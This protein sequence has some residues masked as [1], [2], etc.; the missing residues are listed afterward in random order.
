M[1]ASNANTHHLPGEDTDWRKNIITQLRDRN[2]SETYCF[3]DLICLHNRLLESANTLKLENYQLSIANE[4]LKCEVGSGGFGGNSTLEARLLAHAEELATLHKRRGEHTQ[5]IVDLNNKLQELRKELQTKESSIAESLEVNAGLRAE[6]TRCVSRERELENVNQMLKDEHQALQLAFAALEEKLRKVQE[7]NRQLVERLIRYK[8]KDAEKMNEENDNF[9]NEAFTSPT[10]FL[11][12]TLSKFGKR[13]AKMQKELEDAARDTRGISP[14]RTSLKECPAG[15][16]PS[17]PTKVSSKFTYAF[18]AV[19]NMP[20]RKHNT[21][22]TNRYQRDILIQDAHD[23]EVNAVK[24]SPVDRIVAT[25]GADRKVKLWDVSKGSYDS[26]GMLVGSNAGVMSVDFD[27]TGSL[28]LGAS[29]DFASRVW[30][31]SDLRLRHTLTGH[32]NKVMAAKFLGEPSKV[33]TGSYDRTLKIW[34]LRS[35]ACIETKF[36][37]SSCNDV[38]ISDGS[39]STI[40]SGH[41]DKTIRFWDTRAE[42]SSNNIL[43]QGKVTSL[44]LSRDAHYLLSCV[45]DDTLKLLDLRMNQIIGTFSADGFKVGC[46]WARATFSPDGQYIAVGSSNGSVFIWS[47]SSNKVESVLK[48]HTSSV[49]AVAWHPQGTYLASVD[50]TKQATIWG[51]V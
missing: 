45:R 26:K 51:D 10:T 18:K 29:N 38:V 28:I 42:S 47:V 46:D 48:D 50:R 16:S 24:W 17:L 27:S 32:C 5:Q 31:V 30:T 15:F 40:I 11:M 23:G 20:N 33:V 35:R 49:T 41:F 2:R 14:D 19:S 34:D 39:G 44:D 43:L 4:K 7:E 25:G 13:Q 12:H 21:R 36:A 9:L 3:H 37:G 8:A 1:A 22:L 6:I